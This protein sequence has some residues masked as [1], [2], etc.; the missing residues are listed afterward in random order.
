MS[1]AD[2]PDTSRYITRHLTYRLPIIGRMAREIVD[3]PVEN[4]FAALIGIVS[5]IG[6]AVFIWGLP[7]LIVSALMAAFVTVMF[8]LRITLG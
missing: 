8:L 5:A 4:T 6:V 2:P 3:G 7:A 1:Q